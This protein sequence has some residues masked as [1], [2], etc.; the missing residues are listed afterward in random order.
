M[1][2]RIMRRIMRIF[3]HSA[4]LDSHYNNLTNIMINML[5]S[6]NMMSVSQISSLTDLFAR[7]TFFEMPRY[8]FLVPE[9]ASAHSE[10]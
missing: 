10:R 6:R 5:K 4:A 3:I 9:S 1:T 7:R 2:R 8:I